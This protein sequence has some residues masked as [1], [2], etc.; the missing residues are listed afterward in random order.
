MHRAPPHQPLHL[1]FALKQQNTDQLEDLLL[2]VSDP[3][4]LHYG[5]YI[6]IHDIT[7]MVSPTEESLK[8]VGEWLEKHGVCMKLIY[9]F[10]FKT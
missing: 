4:S 7:A 3:D 6:D 2:Q 10:S 5:K 9:K 1:T 8:V